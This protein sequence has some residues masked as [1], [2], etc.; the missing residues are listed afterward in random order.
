MDSFANADGLHDS[1]IHLGQKEIGENKGVRRTVENPALGF[2]FAIAVLHGCQ[3][4]CGQ[5][6]RGAADRGHRRVGPAP[7]A[8]KAEHGALRGRVAT[9]L[10]ARPGGGGKGAQERAL[11]AKPSP[12]WLAGRRASGRVAG[13]AWETARCDRADAMYE[14]CAARSE[15]G[16]EG[17]SRAAQ[18]RAVPVGPTGRM[19][20]SMLE[21]PARPQDAHGPPRRAR[22][23]GHASAP[24]DQARDVRAAGAPARLPWRGARG[25]L[26]K[27][28]P[29][30]WRWL[31]SPR[32]ESCEHAR[33][34]T[35]RSRLRG[36][37]EHLFRP[38]KSKGFAIEC[39]S[40]DPAPVRT[41]YALPLGAGGLLPAEGPGPRRRGRKTFQAACAVAARPAL[42]AG[43]AALAGKTARQPPHPK[44]SLACAVWGCARLGGGTGY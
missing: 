11:C 10:I 37:S 7:L 17:Q 14:L 8:G 19:K 4:G 29:A 31:I 42:D 27:V 33:G 3:I 25:P 9:R 40:R 13:A 43:S 38:I 41:R 34:S 39:V 28:P 36:G 5:A 21:R 15:G 23:G 12:R 30:H 35:P 44:G 32:G 2:L 6:F 20:A 1:D 22:R 24:E 16:G 26:P 18:D